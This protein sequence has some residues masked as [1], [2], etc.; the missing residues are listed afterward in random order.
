MKS[1]SLEDFRNHLDD[2]LSQSSREDV[3]VT[4]EGQPF[5]VFAKLPRSG[6]AASPEAT[7]ARQMDFEET[8]LWLTAS[9]RVLKELWDNEEDDVYDQV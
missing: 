7:D 3:V 2:Y 1:V 9:D 6:T 8:R 4:R 5:A